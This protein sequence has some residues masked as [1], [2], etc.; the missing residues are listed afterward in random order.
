MK[1]FL[2]MLE[3]SPEELN[4]LVALARRLKA[5]QAGGEAL[6]IQGRILGLVFFDPSLRTRASFEAAMLRFGGHTITLSVGRDSWRLEHRNGVVMDGD[7]AE[8]VR[9]AAAV[10]GAIA[11]CWACVLSPA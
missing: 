2:G 7:R 10:L 9:E 1:H 6:A 5:G 4:R 3:S 8:H 11:T